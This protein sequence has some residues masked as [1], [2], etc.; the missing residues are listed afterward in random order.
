MADPA[1]APKGKSF[2]GQLIFAAVLVV[3]IFV[4]GQM[5][6]RARVASD[7][8]AKADEA[9]ATAAGFVDAAEMLRAK[10]AG[11][12]DPKAWRAK[13]AADDKARAEAFERNRPAVDRLEI[14]TYAW[15]K[16]GFDNVAIVTL[17]ILNKNT[18]AVK[19]ITVACDFSGSSGTKL[20]GL[21]QTIYSSIPAKTSKK[22][23]RL[24]LGL[25]HSQSARASCSLIGAFRA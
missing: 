17:T 15:E 8:Q 22:F 14:S 25:I 18:Y 21:S 10:A 16:G 1:I 5:I 20:S 4:G 23:N 12:D 2:T 7:E 24:N 13:V 3:G 11:L 19:D 6:D 9:A